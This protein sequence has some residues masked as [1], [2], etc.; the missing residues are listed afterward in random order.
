MKASWKLGAAFGIDIFIHWAFLLLPAWVLLGSLAGGTSLLVAAATMGFVLTVFGCVLLHELG[1]A[2]MAR[3]YGVQTRDIIL[4]PIGGV[5]RL[6]RM[7]ERPSEELAVAL[8]GPLVN[9]VI[10]VA[11]YVG[12]SLSGSSIVPFDPT[13]V[14][15]SPFVNLMWANIILVVFNLLPAFPMDGGRVLRALLAMLVP[16][17]RATA[18]AARIG[19]VAAIL[20]A[21]V[22]FFTSWML[23][24]VAA[25]VYLAAGSEAAAARVRSSTRGYR[26]RDAMQQQFHVFAADSRVADLAPELFF[27]DQDDFPVTS[28]SHL[29]GMLSRQDILDAVRRGD[30]NGTAAELMRVVSPTVQ[31][32]AALARALTTMQ[33]NGR[34]SLPVLRANRLVGI[35]TLPNIKR[36]LQLQEATSASAC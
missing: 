20:L 27:T 30:T 31:E 16:Y 2:L 8:A 34:A 7:P 4:L 29:V 28:G 1:H 26:V 11:L 25:F 15:G 24:I 23:M 32:D 10:A 13:L 36:W 12:L 19:Q 18:V 21:V 22:G 5:A 33:A 3:R 35:L 9:V 6:E 14:G 17:E